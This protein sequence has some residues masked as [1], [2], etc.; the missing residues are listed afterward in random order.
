MY[1]DNNKIKEHLDPLLYPLNIQT[2]PHLCKTSE[3]ETSG[4][5]SE[6]SH[7]IGVSIDSGYIKLKI[8]IKHQHLTEY[9]GYK[10]Q[11]LV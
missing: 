4:P 10:D 8:K 9:K 2:R 11:F 5:P 3:G 6:S 7:A 1:N